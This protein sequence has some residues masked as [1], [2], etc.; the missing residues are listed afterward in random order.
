MM[1]LLFPLGLHGEL[2]ALPA[3]K[4]G[5]LLSLLVTR[6]STAELHV[7]KLLTHAS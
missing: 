3:C 4:D 7:S 1:S 6:Q 5:T 2:L